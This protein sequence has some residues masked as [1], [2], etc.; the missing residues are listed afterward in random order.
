MNHLG[1]P[2][3]TFWVALPVLL[4]ALLCSSHWFKLMPVLLITGM[5]VLSLAAKDLLKVDRPERAPVVYTHWDALAKIKIIEYDEFHSGLQ[6]DN[7]ANSPVYRFD[8]VWERPDSEKFGFGIDVRYLIEQFEKCRFLSLGAGGG[9]DVLQALQYGAD[10]IHAVEVL[11][12]INY[13]M[14]KGRLAEYSGN[15]YHDPRVKVVT[16]DARAYIRRFSGHFDLIYS[17]SSNTFAALASGAFALA[18]NYLFTMEAF[19]DYWRSLSDRG[20]IMMEHQFYVPRL[21]PQ[22]MEALRQEGIEHVLNH[23]AVYDLPQMRRK[24]LLVSRQPLN[25][26]ILFNAFGEL[27]PENYNQIH[28]LYPPADSLDQNLISQIVTKGWQAAAV[29]TPLDISPCSDDRPFTAQMGLWKNLNR[30]ALKSV[31]P[32]E[33]TGFPLSKLNLVIILV[34]IGLLIVPLNLIPFLLPG[35]KLRAVPWLYFFTIGMAFM[36]IEV[37]LIQQYTLFIGPSVYSLITILLTLLVASATGSRFSAV[38]KDQVPFWGIVGWLLLN[39]TFYG[40]MVEMLG[41]LTVFPRMAISMLLIFPLGFFMGMP[42][43]KAGLRV[44]ELI[45]WGIAVNGAA[46][47]LGATLILLVAFNYGYRVSLAIAGGLYLVAFGLLLRRK[48]W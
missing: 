12:H 14:T 9:V 3:A 4:A 33:F 6:I 25:A 24:I 38:L 7:A 46:S 47:T 13:L 2:A 41:G 15:I 27:T 29:N 39:I 21:V 23:F 28:L 43:P 1:T 34:V 10:E 22:L 40:G 18:E 42:F 26:E 48:A 36:M 32:Y 19:R 30:T 35:D 16:E 20:F 45:D 31:K 44:K 37:I 11:P 17:L 5:G 8:G